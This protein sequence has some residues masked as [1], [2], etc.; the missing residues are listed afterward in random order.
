MTKQK[1][2]DLYKAFQK[3]PLLWIKKNLGLVPQPLKRGISKEEVWKF[4]KPKHFETW[5]EGKH[6]TWHQWLFFRAVEWAIEGKASRK[7]AIRS[8]HGTGKSASIAIFILWF[9]FCFKDAQ[10]SCTAP[11][12]QQMFDVLWKELSNWHG[13]LKKEIADLYEI[14]DTYVR[15]KERR[16]T[17]FARAA[18]GRKENAEALSG[19]H[20]KHVALI[21]D[22]ASGVHELIFEA[23]RGALTNKNI[24]FITISNPTRLSGF[25]YN[26]FHI[27]RKSWQILGF[28][29]R[30]SPIVDKEFVQGIIDDYG[31]DS[32]TFDIRV[33]GEF[34][35][36]EED[37]F[38]ATDLFE[39]ASERSFPRILTAP[40]ILGVD[41]AAFGDDACAYADRQGNKAVSLGERRGQDTM[42]TVGDVVGFLQEAKV[43]NNPYDFVCVDII[44]IGRGVFDRLVEL[45]N[46]GEIDPYTKFIAVNVAEKPSNIK[47]FGNRRA[48]LW[49]ETR[50][51]LNSSD[52]DSD[53]RNDLCG[54]K[55]KHDSKNRLMMEKKEDMKK[56][57][58]PSPDKG[59]ALVV[60]FAVK[61]RTRQSI[62][63]PGKPKG[64]AV[65]GWQR[66]VGL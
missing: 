58:L 59:D 37:Q 53:Y 50:E 32:S 34:P 65:G 17:W 26:I 55:Y 41:I 1:D 43:Q 60:T 23:V 24:F 29:S 40:R 27:W 25:F 45:Q 49:W 4:Y 46:Q 54:I 7:I 30:E 44:G 10:V 18:T 16:K 47:R 2:I 11:T 5:I 66:S 35:V 38:I 42:V 20:G 3:S 22:E 36:S 33:R 13:K 62:R 39:K 21:G 57:G 63:K 61:T 64:R 31:E 14:L 48:E 51:W 6:L 15:I 56:R 8:G 19:V 12:S 52:V 28:D 9:L